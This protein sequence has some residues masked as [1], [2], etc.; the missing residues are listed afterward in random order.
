MSWLL[1]KLLI[2]VKT[3]EGRRKAAAA[4]LSFLKTNAIEFEKLG[5]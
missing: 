1:S 5:Q 3:K 4:S 2:R